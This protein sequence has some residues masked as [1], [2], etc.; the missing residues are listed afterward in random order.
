MIGKTVSHY[1]ILGKIG[2]G[3]MG[4]VYK[5]EDILLRRSV[6][7]K[8]L[9]QSALG[10]EM[11]RARFLRE[12][13]AA[14]S[15]DHPNI[16]HVYGLESDGEQMFLVMAYVAGQSLDR[17]IVSGLV[18][19]GDA[20]EIAVQ[21][22][23]GL[24][25]AHANGVVHR[26]IK[27]ANIIVTPTRRAVITD[28]GLALLSERSRIT[29]T[30]TVLGT[31]AY[32]SPEQALARSVDHRTDIWSLGVVLYEMLAGRLPFA[33]KTVHAV[34]RSILKEAPQPVTVHREGLPSDISWVM[35]KLLAKRPEERYQH[36]DDLLVDL[37][38]VRRKLP[39]D[40]ESRS[41]VVPREGQIVEP[42]ARTVT[43]VNGDDLTVDTT[44]GT[45]ES[46]PVGGEREPTGLRPAG[47]APPVRRGKWP[48]KWILAGFAL[49]L[50][51]G[52][53]MKWWESLNS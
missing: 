8:F 33:G 24:R 13:Q 3:G 37:R 47:A 28:F 6:A 53:A 40:V 14:G 22:G 10:D 17:R 49:I 26:D 23:E 44:L 43:L 20:L 31:V 36:I 18:T 9:A 11:Q 52:M 38:A 34:C 21:I 7:L 29:K 50:I 42:A 46:N 45:S 25:E 30:G 35:E 2:Q 16:C 12:A 32:M 15:L 1:R 27:S 19:F 4:T 5:A 39:K 41:P 48:W 51:V